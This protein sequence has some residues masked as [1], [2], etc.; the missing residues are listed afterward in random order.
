MMYTVI[1][2]ISGNWEMDVETS[3]WPMSA[4]S[5]LSMSLQLLTNCWEINWGYSW[6]SV[7]SNAWASC[8]MVGRFSN[9]DCICRQTFGMTK[10]NTPMKPPMNNRK[11]PQTATMLGARRRSNSLIEP[12]MT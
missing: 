7:C 8:T 5:V 9:S 12:C 3:H 4:A 2:R 1:A 11:V 6:D 10:N